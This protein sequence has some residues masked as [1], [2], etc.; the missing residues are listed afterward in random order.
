MFRNDF[1]KVLISLQDINLQIYL[2]RTFTPN[3]CCLFSPRPNSEFCL[4]PSS[5]I[6]FPTLQDFFFCFQNLPTNFVRIF[7]IDVYYLRLNAEVVPIV[8]FQYLSFIIQNEVLITIHQEDLIDQSVDYLLLHTATP[9]FE[10]STLGEGEGEWG[11]LL[12]NAYVRNFLRFCVLFRG[13]TNF[14]SI[15]QGGE[16]GRRGG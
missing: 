14:L 9:T 11:C 5:I 13:V 3:V 7:G 10:V 8:S 16:R 1:F 4:I 15:H 2:F 6:F 12:C